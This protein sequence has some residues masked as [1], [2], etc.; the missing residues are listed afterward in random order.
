MALSPDG[1]RVA[2]VDGSGGL[3]IWPFDGASRPRALL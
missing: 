3:R 1:R 2:G